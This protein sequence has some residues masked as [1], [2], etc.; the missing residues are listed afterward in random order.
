MNF[1]EYGFLLPGHLRGV[2]VIGETH[3]LITSE[4]QTFHWEGY[5]L[6]IHVPQG[7]LPAGMAE[8]RLDVKAALT[9]QFEFPGETE[10]VSAVYWL[11]SA[12]KYSHPL[13]VEI[14]HCAKPTIVSGLR[15]VIAKCNEEEMPYKFKTLQRGVFTPF[16]SYGSITLS[17]FS[18]VGVTSES[19]ADIQYCS[20]LYY[21][22]SKVD[23][24]VHFVITKDLEAFITVSNFMG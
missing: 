1:L 8:C 14:Q 19:G 21:M 24:K 2:D 7:S 12:V 5:G 23:W 20:R 22:G 13:T 9:G 4:A 16:S 10:P 17:H 18:I 3:F 11:Y 15:F 6:N